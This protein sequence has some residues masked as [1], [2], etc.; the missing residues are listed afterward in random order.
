MGV[1]VVLAGLLLAV[2]GGFFLAYHNSQPAK[3]DDSLSF[4]ISQATP[5]VGYKSGGGTLTMTG[6]NLPY[7]ATSGYVGGG[8]SGSGNSP[9][10]KG[11]VGWYDGIDNT[12]SGDNAHSNNDST[13]WT[14]LVT[15][16]I[17]PRNSTASQPGAGW[18]ADGFKSSCSTATAT[19][20]AGFFQSTIP[21]GFPT[22]SAANTV[23]IIF[24]TPAASWMNNG[25]QGLVGWGALTDGGGN[26]YQR[27]FPEYSGGILSL[28]SYWC[29]MVQVPSSTTG[30]APLYA[31]D[32]LVTA[33]TTYVGGP[34][35]VGK[36]VT[37]SV[38][39][40]SVTP[41][42]NGCNV[43]SQTAA[44]GEF[45]LGGYNATGTT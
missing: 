41:S 2:G 16:Q 22:G 44:D 27:Y 17:T 8:A 33:T 36:G 1:P 23:E 14:N 7:G 6:A 31:T 3:A 9:S 43:V 34:T 4:T 21:S 39:G 28:P 40:Q 19:N 12:G 13:G 37:V 32:S 15:G 24:R 5:T 25:R 45:F 10:D 29:A 30:A 20:C 26:C 18:T 11:L 38:N 42:C 35:T